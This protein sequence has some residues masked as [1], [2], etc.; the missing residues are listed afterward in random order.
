MKITLDDVV[1]KDLAPDSLLKDENTKYIMESIDY[2]IRK[3]WFEN[4]DKYKL[5]SRLNSMNDQ[6]IELMLWEMHVDYID[7]NLNKEQ[8]TD[9]IKESLLNHMI[10]GT[11]AAVENV[12]SIIFGNAKVTEWFEYNGNP[13]YFRVSTLGSLQSEEDYKRVIEVINTYKNTRSWLE[14]L[15]FERN[16]KNNLYFGILQSKKTINYMNMR[17]IDLPEGNINNYYGIFHSYKVRKKTR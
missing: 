5:F 13:G 14:G 12:C 10:K 15:M 3:I 4:K 9:L 1:V 8:K 7:E 2:V 6:E 11:P 17:E 16:Y